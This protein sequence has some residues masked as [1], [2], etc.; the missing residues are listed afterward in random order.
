MA[1][2]VGWLA[3]AGIG[4]GQQMPFSRDDC[5]LPGG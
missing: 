4:T 1:P 2:P 3:L 5:Q